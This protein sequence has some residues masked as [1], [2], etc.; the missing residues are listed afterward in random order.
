MN[1]ITAPAATLLRRIADRLE[2]PKP[3]PSTI[4]TVD[5]DLDQPVL[6]KG[7][8]VTNDDGRKAIIDRLEVRPAHCPRPKA[9]GPRLAG[10]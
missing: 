10:A 2:A 4:L 7:A 3:A 1:R 9:W 8:Y 6:V 5:W